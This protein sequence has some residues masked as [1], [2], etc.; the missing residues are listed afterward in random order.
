MRKRLFVLVAVCLFLVSSWGLAQEKNMVIEHL[1]WFQTGFGENII[2][3]SFSAPT[4]SP[5]PFASAAFLTFSVPPSPKSDAIF[6]EFWGQSLHRWFFESTPQIFSVNVILKI[7]SP[8]I[9]ADIVVT[10]TYGLANTRN[11]QHINSSE[12]RNKRSWKFILRR[13]GM[14]RPYPDW[15]FVKYADGTDVEKTHAQALLNNLLDSGFD[16]EV[17][18]AGES[19]NMR[20]FQLYAVAVEVTRLIRK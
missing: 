8:L 6:F 1:G 16:A 11:I 14:L 3:T 20:S 12:D 19:Q 7:I 13:D 9:P 4:S 15:W 17:S 10:A 5:I 2:P 18:A